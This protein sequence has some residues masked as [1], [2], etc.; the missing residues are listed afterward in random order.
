MKQRLLRTT[1]ARNKEAVRSVRRPAHHPGSAI[2]ESG[3][4]TMNGHTARQCLGLA[5]VA[6]LALL[7]PLSPAASATGIAPKDTLPTSDNV[8]SGIKAAAAPSGQTNRYVIPN[9]FS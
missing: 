4:A 7:G 1:P 8:K 3:R 5:A 9:Y 2:R 6:A